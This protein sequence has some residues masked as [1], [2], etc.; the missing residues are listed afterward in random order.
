MVANPLGLTEPFRVAP[1]VVTPAAAE[2]VTV[3]ADPAAF[4]VIV[5]FGAQFQEFMPVPLPVAYRV[6]LPAA[7]G[8]V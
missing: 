8:A 3:G 4:T 7:V 1:V 6:T 2:V 5:R